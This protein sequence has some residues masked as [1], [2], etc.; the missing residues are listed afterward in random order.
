MAI[1]N[2]VVWIEYV[3]DARSGGMSL[4]DAVVNAGIYRLR[5]ILLTAAT[6]VGG[7]FPLALFGGVLF[8]PMA[9]A[10][11]V[12]LSLVTFFALVSVPVFYTFF[13]KTEPT[14]VP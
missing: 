6:T 4:D 11:I 5:P 10:M 12:G 3:E 9:W 8:E 1:K 2:A 14:M 7:L 13:M